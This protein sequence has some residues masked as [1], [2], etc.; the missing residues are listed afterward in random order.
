[1]TSQ[2]WADAGLGE[3]L[4]DLESRRFPLD[5][6]TAWQFVRAAYGRAY[7]LSLEHGDER[8]ATEAIARRD[9]LA[10]RVPVS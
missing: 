4:E 3:L 8:I 10:L 1:M 7:V 6:E 2:E 5:F 9:E